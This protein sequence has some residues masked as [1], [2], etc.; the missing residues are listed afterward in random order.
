MSPWSAIRTVTKRELAAYFD[1]PVAYVVIC[2]GLAALSQT[3]FY[4][5][6]RYYTDNVLGQPEASDQ[7]VFVAAGV[8]HRFHSI[9]EELLILVFF[10]PAENE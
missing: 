1:S 3:M 2:I 4:Y 7:L 10:A 9:T 8:E 5:L 6:L